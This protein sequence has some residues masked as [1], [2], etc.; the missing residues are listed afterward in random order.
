VHGLAMGEILLSGWSL[1]VAKPNN[2][3]LPKN[4]LNNDSICLIS[5]ALCLIRLGTNGLVMP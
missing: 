4:G 3:M 2:P 5:M 1:L